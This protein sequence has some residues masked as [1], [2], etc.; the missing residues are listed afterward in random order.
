MSTRI[1]IADDDPV[2]LGLL[3]RRLENWKYSVTAVEDG[4]AA[5]RE[6]RR[7]GAP[8]LVILDWMMPGLP[9]PDIVRLLRKEHNASYTYVMLLTA[10]SGRSDLVAGLD[11]GADD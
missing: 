5:L 3:K 1:L 6:L 4:A 8:R 9:G 2:S 10:K 11:A 7:P